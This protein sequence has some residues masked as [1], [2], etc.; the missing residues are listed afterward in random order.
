M[1]PALPIMRAETSVGRRFLGSSRASI[2][3]PVSVYLW[4]QDQST[5]GAEKLRVQRLSAVRLRGNEVL[6]NGKFE[7]DGMAAGP[8]RRLQ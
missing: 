1:A 7:M 8:P 5:I 2:C 4:Y 3:L 6:L